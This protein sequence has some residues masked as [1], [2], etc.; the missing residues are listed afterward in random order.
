ML[1][2]IKFINLFT[3]AMFGRGCIFSKT[4]SKQV[5][6][7]KAHKIIRNWHTWKVSTQKM[8]IIGTQEMF[9]IS[10]QEMFIIGTQEMFHSLGTQEILNS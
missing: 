10:T 1:K 2:L 7:L 3:L 8:F 4:F 6:I 5:Q 9:I